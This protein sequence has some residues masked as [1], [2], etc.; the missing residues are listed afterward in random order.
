M[1]NNIISNSIKYYNPYDP[2]PYLD[3]DVVI[4][5]SEAILNISDNGIGM[6]QEQLSRIFDMFYRASEDS[7]GSGIGLYIVKEVVDTLNGSINVES[8]IGE[9]SSF[10]ITLPNLK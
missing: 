5:R 2:K 4:T 10:M 3:I 6:N 7:Y 9:G 8:T 1:L